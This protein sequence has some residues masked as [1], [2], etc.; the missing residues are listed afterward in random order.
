MKFFLENMNPISTI[1]PNLPKY[2]EFGITDVLINCIQPMSNN[3]FEKIPNTLQP[4]APIIGS[5]EIG[6]EKELRELCAAAKKYNIRIVVTVILDYV[7]PCLTQDMLTK[8]QLSEH[9][10]LRLLSNPFDY[11]KWQGNHYD[12]NTEINWEMVNQRKSRL[13]RQ[14]VFR[15]DNRT[16]YPKIKLNS[17]S[18]HDKHEFFLDELEACG[19]SGIYM[20]NLQFFPLNYF[21]IM[22]SSFFIVTNELITLDIHPDVYCISKSDCLE[23]EERN[24]IFRIDNLIPIKNIIRYQANYLISQNHNFIKNSVKNNDTWLLKTLTTSYQLYRDTDLFSTY[25]VKNIVM[26]F[27]NGFIF[28]NNSDKEMKLDKVNFYI[29]RILGSSNLYNS[30]PTDSTR[31]LFFISLTSTNVKRQSIFKRNS[32]VNFLFRSKVM[33][34]NDGYYLIGNNF[35]VTLQPHD[36]MCFFN[37]T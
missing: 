24:L 20:S 23:K 16:F 10:N 4:L 21:K 29:P 5:T 6:S 30:F 17:H 1:I 9:V 11:L 3:F 22:P 14:S 12:F 37:K 34:A 8:E 25:L 13:S 32:I 31:S 33:D 36:F 35:E 7:G 2:A 19:V 28:F 26:I 18:I 15:L 27:P